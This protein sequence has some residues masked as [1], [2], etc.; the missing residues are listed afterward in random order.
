MRPSSISPAMA[1]GRVC[2]WRGWFALWADLILDPRVVDQTSLPL[3]GRRLQGGHW[4]SA[5]S[6]RFPGTAD[7]EEVSTERS[8]SY[9]ASGP[10]R[11]FS[12]PGQGAPAMGSHRVQP[13]VAVFSYGLTRLSHPVSRA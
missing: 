11:E 7:R 8:S 2:A 4:P 3:L 9:M 5:R 1:L 12:A 13:G 10:G 6:P